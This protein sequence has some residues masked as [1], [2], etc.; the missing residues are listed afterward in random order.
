MFIATDPKKK[1]SLQRSDTDIRLLKEP[2]IS[3]ISVSYKHFALA[4]R[5]LELL[6]FVRIPPSPDPH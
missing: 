1:L 6:V 4:G 2:T 3:N 5:I